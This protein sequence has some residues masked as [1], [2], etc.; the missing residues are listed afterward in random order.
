MAHRRTWIILYLTSLTLVV[1][2]FAFLVSLAAFGLRVGAAPSSLATWAA[3]YLAA[4]AIG[5]PVQLG[6]LYVAAHAYDTGDRA[7]ADADA[8]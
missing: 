5:V 4:V 8:Q 7:A 6:V 1:F 2:G 3:C